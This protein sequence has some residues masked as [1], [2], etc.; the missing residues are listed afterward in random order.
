MLRGLRLWLTCAAIA[1]SARPCALP[2]RQCIVAWKHPARGGRASGGW[3]P[4]ERQR[5]Q[6]HLGLEP[7]GPDRKV[8][9]ERRGIAMAPKPVR[10]RSVAQRGN[11]DRCGRHGSYSYKQDPRTSL[12]ASVLGEYVPQVLH[13]HSA[14]GSRTGLSYCCALRSHPDVSQQSMPRVP[15]AEARRWRGLLPG[16]GLPRTACGGQRCS[17]ATPA[18]ACGAACRA[19]A[20]RSARAEQRPAAAPAG[21]HGATCRAAVLC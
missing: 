14:I 10:C 21:R 13:G 2:T 3:K 19:A 7:A 17:P 8:S 12:A 18:A 20:L 1:A 15:Q 9:L 11:C 6:C 16:P 4:R 5:A